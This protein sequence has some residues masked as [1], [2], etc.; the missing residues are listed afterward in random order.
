MVAML[1]VMTRRGSK[2]KKTMYTHTWIYVCVFVCIMHVCIGRNLYIA[3]ATSLA[4]ELPF[5]YPKAARS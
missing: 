1:S 2:E 4:L 5:S 3:T